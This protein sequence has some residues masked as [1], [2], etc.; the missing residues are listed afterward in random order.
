MILEGP[1]GLAEDGT[2]GSTWQERKPVENS[3]LVPPPHAKEVIGMPPL[4]KF[5]CVSHNE[6][7]YNPVLSIGGSFKAKYWLITNSK[8]VTVKE[9]VALVQECKIILHIW[10]HKAWMLWKTDLSVKSSDLGP[11]LDI[12]TQ[13]L[14]VGNICHW[15]CFSAS[16]KQVLI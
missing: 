12:K 1:K 2:R 11:P 16:K 6:F 9:T 14:H 5:R 4:E 8:N 13:A 10:L 15:S 7:H 3:Q